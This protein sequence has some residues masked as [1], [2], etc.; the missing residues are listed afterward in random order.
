MT[1]Q[2]PTPL[3]QYS[4]EPYSWH[5]PTWAVPTSAK[6][7]FPTNST[8]RLPRYEV[9]IWGWE[10]TWAV[11]EAHGYRAFIRRICA[12][13]RTAFSTS[14]DICKYPRGVGWLRGAHEDVLVSLLYQRCLF[15][16]LFLIFLAI[17]QWKRSVFFF[18]PE[19]VAQRNRKC[20]NWHCQDRGI[21]YIFISK[22]YAQR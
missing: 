18:S 12:S 8:G 17:I 15:I 16:G 6:H 19:N 7:V 13:S 2:R 14:F 10:M 1:G 3:I 11:C 4:R 21:S 20:S 22:H 9:E 5:L